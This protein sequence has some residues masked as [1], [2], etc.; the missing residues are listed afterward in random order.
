[1]RV[2]LDALRR[3]IHEGDYVYI[4]GEHIYQVTCADGVDGRYARNIRVASVL[5]PKTEFV[6]NA[7]E[8][9]ILPPGEVMIWLLTATKEKQ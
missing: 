4:G 8:A 1:M 7:K 2:P 5:Y 6:T 3:E 9:I